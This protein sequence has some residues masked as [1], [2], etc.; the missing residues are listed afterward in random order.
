MGERTTECHMEPCNNKPWVDCTWADWDEWSAC[1]KCSGEMKRARTIKRMPENLGKP[2]HFEDSEQITNCT[3][4]CHTR[5]V[6]DWT[7]WTEEESCSATCGTGRKKMRRILQAKEVNE[8]DAAS[9]FDAQQ[10]AIAQSRLQNLTVSFA[11]GSLVTFL[12][13]VVTMRAFRGESQSHQ[14]VRAAE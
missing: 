5:V 4:G 7:E 2:C 1:D 3:R 11:C 6:C 12:V 10:P 9:K 13:L 8:T 14:L